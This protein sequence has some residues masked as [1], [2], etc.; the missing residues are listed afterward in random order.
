[1]HSCRSDKKEKISKARIADY[2]RHGVVARSAV[3]VLEI[4]S[5]SLELET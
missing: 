3:H 1:V 4:A 5:V 2:S